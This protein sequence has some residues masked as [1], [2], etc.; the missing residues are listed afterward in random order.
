M[1]DFAQTYI[2]RAQKEKWAIPHFN[3]A[4]AETL[5]AIIKISA[6]LKSPVF[7]ANSEGERA[8]IGLLEARSLVDAFKAEFEIPVFLNADHT[9]GWEKAK[10]AVDAGYDAILIDGSAFSFEENVAMTKKVVEYAK[11]KNPNC[12]IEGEIGYLRGESKVQKKVEIKESDLASP[13]DAKRFVE[14]THVDLL[15]PAVGN[16]HGIVLESKEE[17]RP[18]LI[19][20]IRDAIAPVG[21]VLHGASGLADEQIRQAI[22]AGVS[23]IHINTELR[24]AFTKG[25]KKAFETSP[26]EVVPYKYLKAAGAEVRSVV[27][28]KIKLFGSENKL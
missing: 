17:I 7:V 18:A 19:E 24:V 8:F 9:K 28:A 3:F 20:K 2:A 21:L 16:I 26:E 6:E 14:T 10:E 22:H 27:R 11:K 13:E 1:T 5:R 15:A 12:L 4:D 25:L 23:I